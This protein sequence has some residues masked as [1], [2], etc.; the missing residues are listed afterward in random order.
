MPK[1]GGG[2]QL[3]HLENCTG[4]FRLEICAKGAQEGPFY[5][6]AYPLGLGYI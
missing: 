3:G 5:T 6:L 1:M 2:L 4:A